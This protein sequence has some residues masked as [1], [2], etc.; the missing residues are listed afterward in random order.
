[1][2]EP[3]TDTTRPTSPGQVRRPKRERRPRQDRRPYQLPHQKQKVNSVN[4]TAHQERVRAFEKIY[5]PCNCELYGKC[6]LCVA[7]SETKEFRTFNAAA[8]GPWS[9]FL[10]D[11]IDDDAG[12]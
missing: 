7:L 3:K 5:G 1:M 12:G 2:I 9:A 8:T 10:I 11:D 6:V 4:P